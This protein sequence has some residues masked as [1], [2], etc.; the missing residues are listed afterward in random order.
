MSKWIEQG[1]LLK[2][3]VIIPE[4]TNYEVPKYDVIRV[5]DLIRII[6]EMPTIS[7][8]ELEEK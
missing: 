1:K 4:G 5:K 2:E 8:E 6:K 3:F 7:K